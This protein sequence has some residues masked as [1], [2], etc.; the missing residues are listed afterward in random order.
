MFV[1]LIHSRPAYSKLGQDVALCKRLFIL[2]I[3]GPISWTHDQPE[4]AEELLRHNTGMLSVA[5][6]SN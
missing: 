2:M 6:T 1:V 4:E 5:F 3:G